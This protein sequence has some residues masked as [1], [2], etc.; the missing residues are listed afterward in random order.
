[1]KAKNKQIIAAGLFAVGLCASSHE[2]WSQ[3]GGGGT[4]ADK[5]ADMERMRNEAKDMKAAADANRARVEQQIKAMEEGENPSAPVPDESGVGA[6][7]APPPPAPGATDAPSETAVSD[8]ATGDGSSDEPSGLSIAGAPLPVDVGQEVDEGSVVSIFSD[9]KFL[10]MLGQNPKFVYEAV[11]VPDP[12]VFPPVRNEA[13]KN[14]LWLKADTILREAGLDLKKMGKGMIIPPAAK[15]KIQEAIEVIQS[16]SKFTSNDP[17]YI[18][19]IAKRTA[20][21]SKLIEA[22][23]PTTPGVV[24]PVDVPCDLPN[25]IRANVR[26]IVASSQKPVCLVG[27]FILAVGESIP[28]FPN[29]KIGA[30]N[31]GQIVFEVDCK[32]TEAKKFPITVRPNE[33]VGFFG[34]S[35]T[36]GRR[37]GR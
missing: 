35:L 37:R 9:P 30:I 34:G 28:D 25:E 15:P 13:I 7:D 23:P 3:P 24:A 5:I 20:E 36:G 14:E 17:R 32:G 10:A 31:P 2:L 27:D 6:T 19:P 21:L 26:G 18:E 29:V 16:V 33:E 11:N 4:F 22:P 8:E 1:M 12:M